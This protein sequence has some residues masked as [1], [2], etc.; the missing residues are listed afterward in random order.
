MTSNYRQVAGSDGKP[1]RDAYGQPIER[2]PTVD[3]VTLRQ[4]VTVSA[5]GQRVRI[6][7]SNYYGL[8]PLTVSGARIALRLAVAAGD[9]RVIRGHGLPPA[10]DPMRCGGFR[11]R[12]RHVQRQARRQPGDQRDGETAR[13][14]AMG[15]W[16]ACGLGR[17][18]SSLGSFGRLWPLSM[19]RAPERNGTPAIDVRKRRV[20]PWARC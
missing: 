3:H 13:S 6:R 11:L 19:Q 5:G 17:Q 10:G 18:E 1:E 8:A 20:L 15:V 4:R 9:H 16:H 14:V 12:C 7:L 2:A